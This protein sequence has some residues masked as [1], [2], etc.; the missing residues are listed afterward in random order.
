MLRISFQPETL[1]QKAGVVRAVLGRTNAWKDW[2]NWESGNVMESLKLVGESISGFTKWGFSRLKQ[3]G[4]SLAM[5][6]MTGVIG[7]AALLTAALVYFTPEA[8]ALPSSPAAISQ[9]S[10]LSGP[11]AEA[12]EI[13]GTRVT[14]TSRSTSLEFCTLFVFRAAPTHA[15]S[16]SLCAP[17]RL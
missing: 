12:P 3:N 15:V 4:N 10:Q 13:S 14:S 8:E 1:E 9:S 7:G 2:D 5:P 11:D 6:A 17:I 16:A